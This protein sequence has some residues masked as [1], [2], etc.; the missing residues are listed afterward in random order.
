[1]GKELWRK[2]QG[3]T[4]IGMATKVVEVF[5][6]ILT[7]IIVAQMIDVGV[8]NHD[9]PYVLQH[10]ALLILFAGIGYC[11]TLI[12]QRMAA[13][14]SQG[15]GTDLRRALFKKINSFGAAEVDT[16]STPTLVTRITNDVNQVQLAI[17][18]S[19]RQFV[20]WPLLA[21]GS[22]IASFLIDWQLGLIFLCCTLIVA[23]VFYLVMRKSIPYYTQ[24][25]EKLDHISLV[26]REA[27][28]GVR[29]IRVFR[30]E[31]TEY[32]RFKDA[33]QDQRD[34]AI[35]VGKLSSILNPASYLIMNLGVVA[36]L[37][38]GGF[39]VDVGVLQ[40]G[41]IVAFV[42]Y[43]A[44]T[45]TSIAYVA[46]LIILINR[47]IVS[48]H[49]IREVLHTEPAVKYESTHPV[50]LEMLSTTVPAINFH[51]VSFSYGKGKPALAHVDLSLGQ[52]QTLGIIGGTGSGKSTFV[53]LLTRL[54]DADEGSIDV[55]GTPIKAWPQEQ[56]R[57]AVSCVPQDAHLVSGT[58]RSNLTWRKSDA[59]NEELMRA[60]Q[61][62]Q[63]TDVVESKKHGLDE[64][65]ESGG[66]N[67]SGGQRQR[68]TIA[69]ALVG[70]PRIIVLDDA[71]SA[72][73]FETDAKL[74][75]A[76]AGLRPRLTQVIISQ[77][78]SAVMGADEILVLHHGKVVGLGKHQEL[79]ESCPIYHEICD[80]QL[81]GGEVH[82]V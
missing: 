32:D 59:T 14:V 11:F 72:L 79:Y 42:N 35:T 9:A 82:Y 68:L 78:V 74:R 38:A 61:L 21:I 41:E 37:W 66:K 43:M 80:S 8:A 49:R 12:C 28:S 81:K 33:A 50:E 15:V 77:R 62:A 7:P 65:A 18:M 71:A 29:V 34:T 31:D 36:V 64:E 2:Y 1:M 53:N 10:G 26:T 17:A 25:Q 57:Q 76:L 23:L 67:F 19:I 20:R 48:A 54:Y 44:L 46:N 30:R 52:G 63:A 22:I 60:V 4:L 24:M 69:R 47:G 58:I 6:E 27:L 56:L 40:Q 51:D 16:F 13:L 75:R 73:D 55:L 39:K 45:L 3:R 5:F 70:D